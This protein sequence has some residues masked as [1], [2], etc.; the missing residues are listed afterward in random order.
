MVTRMSSYANV[1]QLVAMIDQYRD[2]VTADQIPVPLPVMTGG[3]PRNVEFDLG[4][5]TVDFVAD[6]DERLAT[7]AGDTL[8]QDNT[9]KIATDGRNATMYPPLANLPT[10]APENSRVEV[11]ADVIW[12]CHGD[13]AEIVIPADKYGPDMTGA[14]QL[15][16]CDRGTP[17]P[18]DTPHS[19]NV[20][21]ELRAA[22]VRRGMPTE[23]VAFMHDHDTPKQ[24]TALAQACRD[25]RIRVLITSTKKGGTGLNVQRALKQLINMDPAWTAADMEQRIGRIVRQGNTFDT[26]DVVNLVARRSYDAMMYQYVARKAGFVQ[27]I[28]REDVPATMEDLGGD[29]AASWAQTKA[30]ATGDP[31]FVQQVEADQHVTSLL[32]R[33]DIVHNTNAARDATIT[34]LHRRIAAATDTLPGLRADSH[35]AAA[36]LGTDRTRRLWEFPD[37]RT[38]PDSEP[39]DLVTALTTALKAANPVVTRAQH[40]RHPRRRRRDPVTVTYHQ[41]TATYA[42]A[43]TGATPR[44]LRRDEMIDVLDH[45]SAARGLI[46]KIRN[47]ASTIAERA[48]S[49]ETQSSRGARTRRRPRRTRARVRPGRRTRT[50]KLRAAELRLEVNSRENSPQALAQQ[51]RDIERRR[52]AGQYPNWSLDLNPTPAWAD[53]HHGTHPAAVVAT[54]PQRMQH[55]ADTW[56]AGEQDRATAKQNQLWKPLDATEHEWRYGHDPNTGLPGARTWWADRQWRWEAYDGNGKPR[57]RR[58]TPARSHEHRTRTSTPCPATATSTSPDR[59]H[60]P[61]PAPPLTSRD[62]HR[63][64]RIRYR[65]RHR[66]RPHRQHTHARSSVRRRPSTRAT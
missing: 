3:V 63:R 46:Q 8:D 12:R 9:L 58:I 4:Q 61:R 22:L 45:D 65:Q 10:P 32:A 18:T 49:L 53:R 62:T 6:L 40:A 23:A 47:N 59:R 14:F 29:F 24:K 25:G 1:P 55:A 28:R 39:A 33:R 57:D 43:L 60:R 19:R 42:V 66:H 54:V 13:H 5:H 34:A 17:K 30:A 41:Q 2:V 51:A 50:A 21:T 56:A 11:A 38:V 52:A 35:R 7:L 27:Q 36:W 20:Y 16:F 31:V 15:V 64:R 26:V 44:Y 48:G 37:G